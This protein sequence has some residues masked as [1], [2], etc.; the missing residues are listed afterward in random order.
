MKIASAF[1]DRGYGQNQPEGC[2]IVRELVPCFL[3]GQPVRGEFA[4]GSDKLASYLP[5]Q[6]RIL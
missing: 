3:G 4:R 2:Q 6:D 5:K 1:E